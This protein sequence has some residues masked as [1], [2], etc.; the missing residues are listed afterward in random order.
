MPDKLPPSL[1]SLR[2]I[3]FAVLRMISLLCESE[4]EVFQKYLD[5]YN[6]LLD[7][8]CL[9]NKEMMP[10]EQYSASREDAEYFVRNILSGLWI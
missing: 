3:K 10:P 1:E 6:A 2:E 7:R 8:F 4:G 9:E 5:E